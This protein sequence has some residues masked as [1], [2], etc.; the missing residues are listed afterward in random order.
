MSSV[1]L[2]SPRLPSLQGSHYLEWVQTPPPPLQPTTFLPCS[3]ELFLSSCS[4]GVVCQFCPI[5]GA[6]CE[7]PHITCKIAK[8]MSLL[9]GKVQTSLN[10]KTLQVGSLDEKGRVWWNIVQKDLSIFYFNYYYDTAVLYD[11]FICGGMSLYHSLKLDFITYK[12]LR[13]YCVWLT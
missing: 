1:S 2:V 11:T 3:P 5:N 8:E 9:S 13:V 7:L 12:L 6:V 10:H 4:P